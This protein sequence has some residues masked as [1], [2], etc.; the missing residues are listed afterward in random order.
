M[1]VLLQTFGEGHLLVT[2]PKGGQYLQ[3][4]LKLTAMRPINI[5]ILISPF[6]FQCLVFLYGILLA[7]TKTDNKKLSYFFSFQTK[8]EIE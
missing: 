3:S 5:I 1:A 8:A 7:S 6:R 2:F 4:M